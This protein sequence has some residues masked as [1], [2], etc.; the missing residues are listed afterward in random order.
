MKLVWLIALLV[1]SSA[2]FS[3]TGSVVPEQSNIK[4]SPQPVQAEIKPEKDIEGSSWRAEWQKALTEARKE[5]RVVVYGPPGA[6]IRRALIEEFQKAFPGIDVHYTGAGGAQLAPKVKAE[7]RA[8]I[9]IPDIHIGGTTS[10]VTDLKQ[11]SL[12]IEPWLT[13]PEVKDGKYWM[14]GKL[15]YGDIEE[16]YNLVFTTYGKVAMAYN[17]SLLNPSRAREMSYWDLAGTEFKGKIVM[18]DPRGAGPGQATALF[19]YMEPKLGKNFLKALAANELVFSRDDRQILEWIS[20]GKYVV[21]LGHSDL[22]VNE[23]QRAGLPNIN[24]QPVLKE[25]TFAP[26]GFGSMI[27]LDNTPHP[28]AARVYTNWL[29]SR[30]GQIAWSKA[31]NQPSRRVDLPGDIANT[32]I[33]L[34]P[35][36]SYLL[37][38]KEEIVL[39]RAEVLEAIYEIFGR[40]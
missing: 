10:I 2:L 9:Y 5:G 6:D 39:K 36:I 40:N 34:K 11:Y 15:D 29:L 16:K 7:R 30:D 14:G 20:R 32:E 24:S 21:A 13:L 3:C 35:G 26:N 23:L 12:P 31:T 28:A 27:I 22:M 38:Y 25:G 18:N 4:P 1:F 33:M 19:Y 37:T 17:P 8:G